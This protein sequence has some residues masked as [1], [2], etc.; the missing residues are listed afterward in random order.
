MP[1][2]NFVISWIA[3]ND[4]VAA[5]QALLEEDATVLKKA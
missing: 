1:D 3:S 5:Q 2:S 4:S